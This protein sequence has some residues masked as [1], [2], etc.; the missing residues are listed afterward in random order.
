[1]KAMDRSRRPLRRLAIVLAVLL[2]GAAAACFAQAP[3]KL[4]VGDVI[5]PPGNYQ[6]PIQRIYG[7]LKTRPGS[8]Y[9]PGT[10]DEDVR[11]LYETRA[12]ANV[13]VKKTDPDADGKI[14]VYF[15]LTPL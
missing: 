6:I 8:E 14:T 9:N 15:L 12:F 3:A 4:T 7:L 10:I 2:A 11:A 13:Q 5:V 1:M